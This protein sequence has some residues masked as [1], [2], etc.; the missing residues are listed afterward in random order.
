MN[1]AHD[2][3]ALLTIGLVGT[4]I[5]SVMGVVIAIV[6]IAC[7]VGGVALSVPAVLSEGEDEAVIPIVGAGTL[8]IGF[9]GLYVAVNTVK[10]LLCWG[11]WQLERTWLI[12]LLALTVLGLLLD[13]LFG[14]GTAIGCCC[15]PIPVLVDL[16]LFAGIVQVLSR[17]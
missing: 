17:Q 4:V 16:T 7:I 6:A 9:L 5:L 10:L 8:G 1:Q 11:A 15:L 13:L 14:G 12:L 2:R 3:P